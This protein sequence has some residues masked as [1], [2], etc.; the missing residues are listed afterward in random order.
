M[1]RFISIALSGICLVTAMLWGA[2]KNAGQNGRRPSYLVYVG[3]Y[4][5][6]SSK[7][8]YA[9]RFDAVAGESTKLG[10]AAE[11]TNPSF[12]VINPDRTR[13]YAVNEISNYENQNTG[14]ISSFSID[15]ETGKLTFLNEVA[16]R[17]AD[18]M[19]G[20]DDGQGLGEGQL[21]SAGRIHALFEDGAGQRVEGRQF[22][23]GYAKGDS[24]VGVGIA[25]DGQYLI[26]VTSE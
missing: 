8:I 22:G 13:L 12:L 25:V 2:E 20:G 7:G 19:L 9:Y 4:T 18:P 23:R 15:R 16:S 10:V 24:Q 17:G 5:G 1:R 6:P 3:T 11:T 21:F 26:T 14:S